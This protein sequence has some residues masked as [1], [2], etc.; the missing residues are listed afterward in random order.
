[1]KH[2]MQKRTLLAYYRFGCPVICAWLGFEFGY[3]NWPDN[4]GAQT[5]VYFPNSRPR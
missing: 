2:F 3:D 5:G 1:M 4:V